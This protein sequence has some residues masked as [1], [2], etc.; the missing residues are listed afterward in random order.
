MKKR[1][2]LKRSKVALMVALSLAI[3][4]VGA[5]CGKDARDG[6]P[7]VSPTPTPTNIIQ[8]SNSNNFI[9]P[10][11]PSNFAGV[12]NN[13]GSTV[14]PTPSPATNSCVE[15][16]VDKAMTAAF[17]GDVSQLTQ[18]IVCDKPGYPYMDFQALLDGNQQ[19][20]GVGSATSLPATSLTC[21]SGKG[22]QLAKIG[23]QTSVAA[24]DAVKVDCFGLFNQ[25]IKQYYQHKYYTGD[26]TLSGTI[27][28]CQADPTDI[29]PSN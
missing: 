19:S 27:R 6:L 5:G 11:G 23:N 15:L 28:C 26:I 17:W 3:M 24:G 16:P 7:D 29:A 20:N 9:P 4:V 12:G 2:Q 25:T 14:T 1:K 10:T 13:T 22:S 18:T 21:T 8:A